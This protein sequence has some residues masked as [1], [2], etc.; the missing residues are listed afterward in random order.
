MRT[1]SWRFI[2]LVGVL[3]LGLLAAAVRAETFTNPQLISTSYDP[4]GVASADLNSDGAI[5]LVYVDGVNP[6]VVHILQ[7]RGNGTFSHGQDISLP[8]AICGYRSCPVNLADVTHDGKTDIIMGGA[9]SNSGQ[10]AVLTGR[11]DGT[12]NPAVVTSIVNTNGGHPSFNTVMGIGDVNGDG[13]ADLVIADSSSATLYVLLGNNTGKFSVGSTVTFYFTGGTETYLFDLNGDGHLDIVVNDLIG[14]N[15]YVLQGNGDGTFKAATVFLSFALLFTDVDGDGHPD[16]VGEVY[17]GQVQIFKGKPDGTF[18]A[19]S[20]IATVPANAQLVAAGDV[21]N[22]GIVDLAFLIPPGIGVL[23]GNGNLTYGSLLPTVAG[24]V[25]SGFSHV[26]V[27]QGDFNRDGYGDVAMAVSGGISVLTGNGDGTFVSADSYELGHAVGSTA[28]GDFNGDQHRDVAVTVSATYPLLLLGN[29]AGKFTLA[30]DQNQSYGTQPPSPSIVAADFNGDGKRDLDIVERTDAFP[31]GQPFLLFG[32][33]D[34]TFGTPSPIDAG[35]SLVGDVNSD[36]R[37]DLVFRSINVNSITTLLGRADGAFT[38]MMTTMIYPAGDVAALGDLNHDGKPDLLVFENLSM[39]AWLGKGDG[40]FTQSQLVSN[41]PQPIYAQYVTIA[42]L[43]GDGNGDIVVVS[44][45]AAASP[46]LIYY[47]NGDGTFQDAAL[48][49]ISHWYTQLVI[50][51]VNLD[52]KPDLILSDDNGIA[53]M[54]NLGSR[55]FGNELHFVAGQHLAGLSVADVNG[56]GY[57]DII[58]ANANGST[59]SVLL[60]DP[61]GNP[62]GGAA[63]NGSFTISPEPSLFAQPVTLTIVMSVPAGP[64]PTGSVSFSVDGSFLTTK[65]LANGKATYILNSALTT[66]THQFVVTYYGDNT[67]AAETFS[68]LHVVLPPVYATTTVLTA[69]P[70]VIYTS[71]TVSLTATVS[72][73]VPVP[74]GIVTF[75]D[76]TQTLGSRTIYGN[77]VLV[78]DTNLLAAGTHSLT[79][80]YHGWQDP[81]NEQAI[82]QPSVSA[83]VTVVVNSI[84]TTTGLQVSS[85]SPTAGT[86][87]TFAA[88]VASGSGVPFGS[89]TFYDGNVALGTSSLKADGS[90]TYSTA[91]L[92]IGSHSITAAFN[93]NATFA[94]ST[95]AAIV[96][97]VTPAATNLIPAA[98]IVS[99]SS[100]GDESVMV[101]NVWPQSSDF[102]GEVVF[103]DGGTILGKAQVDGHGTASLSVPAFRNGD[104]T[105]FASFTGEARLAPA[106]SPALAERLPENREGF[107]LTASAKSVDLTSSG[108]DVFF[109][110]VPTSGFQ[111]RIQLSCVDGIPAG[112]SC[113]FSPDQLFSGTSH[114]RIAQS[115]KAGTRRSRTVLT[116]GI[117]GIFGFAFLLVGIQRRHKLGLFTVLYLTVLSFALIVGCGNPPAPSDQPQMIVLSTQATAGVG[118]GKVIHSAQ[119]LLNI[120]PSK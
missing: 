87:V 39:R 85:T 118:D 98:V 14:A 43:D 3:S 81:F 76:G 7:G 69:T 29:G 100:A 22:D 42:D 110:V 89:A 116:P 86:V 57:L 120:Q 36:G 75:M 58:T 56:D 32:A 41:S 20:V 51:D 83:P 48:L 44:Y 65:T 78:F 90:C 106:A 96:V 62:G 60:N 27:A 91:S 102:S 74:A 67:Y 113:S 24:S 105:F 18:A 11:G 92:A 77:P 26:G 79:A 15:T 38:Q 12:F 46:L 73:V 97:T 31:F 70:T 21:N 93:A 45:P 47:G 63:S 25:V 28:I 52:G 2:S 1:S 40:T 9:D 49:P 99:V 23:L 6:S 111:Q 13:A 71:Q 104:H 103:L 33:G 50:A 117:I 108:S 19:A 112:Y 119:I 68:V 61:D 34:G 88:N 54:L 64:V 35:P 17:P 101:A 94:A 10:I 114:L 115:S 84:P 109:T 66:G 55:S 53:V 37:S 80:V 59:V 4:V 8:A 16:I 82:F 72:S 5:D 95:S 107:S 30:T